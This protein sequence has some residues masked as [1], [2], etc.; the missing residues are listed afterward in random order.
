MEGKDAKSIWK[1]HKT[2]KHGRHGKQRNKKA[3]KQARRQTSKKAIKQAKWQ[4]SKKASKR[5]CPWGKNVGLDQ[6]SIVSLCWSMDD[7][8]ASKTHAWTCKKACKD[9]KKPWVAQTSM[10]SI[11]SHGAEKGKGMHKAT[12]IVVMDPKWLHLD[13]ASWASDVTI[14][15]QTR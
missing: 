4:T 8:L 10:V 14:Q 9:A 13:K 15:L 11:S 3:S 7:T 12:G 2:N 5:W 1:R 6:M